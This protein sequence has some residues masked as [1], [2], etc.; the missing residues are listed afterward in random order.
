MDGSDRDHAG[1]VEIRVEGEGSVSARVARDPG[2]GH[3]VVERV[4][5]M[6][7]NPEPRWSQQGLQIGCI[8]ILHTGFLMV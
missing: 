6:A 4:M 8:P 1:G 5:G 2:I 7:V 3:A